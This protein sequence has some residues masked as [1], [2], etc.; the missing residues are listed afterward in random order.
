MHP[1]PLLRP[2]ALREGDCIGLAAPA[3]PSDR[4]AFLQGVD[5]LQALGFRV[6]YTP[7]LLPDT[8]ILQETMRGVPP[9]CTRSSPIQRSR[10]YSVAVVA[11]ARSACSP[12]SIPP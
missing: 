11:M 6:H 7:R 10:R 4:Q 12:I 8:A 2:A 5:L 9:N 1:S 3:S